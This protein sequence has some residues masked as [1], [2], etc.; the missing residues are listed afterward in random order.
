MKIHSSYKILHV[1]MDQQGKEVQNTNIK[2]TCH[3]RTVRET[4]NQTRKIN[5]IDSGSQCTVSYL[6]TFK[7]LTFLWKINLL[8]L[9]LLL[10]EYLRMKLLMGYS[11]DRLKEKLML[12]LHVVSDNKIPFRVPF[13]YIL[14]F[15]C[16]FRK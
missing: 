9:F 7:E 3:L 10:I 4:E 14:S 13:I 5:N 12:W 8:L 16:L 2:F 11:S 15:N 6:S 1:Y